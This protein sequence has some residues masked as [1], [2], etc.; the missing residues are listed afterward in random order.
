MEMNGEQELEDIRKKSGRWKTQSQ[1]ICSDDSSSN[2]NDGE[3]SDSGGDNEDEPAPRR[4][5]ISRSLKTAD[6]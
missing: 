2:G 1:N 4:H 3:S 5:E 6:L